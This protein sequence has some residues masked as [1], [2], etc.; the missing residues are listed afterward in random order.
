MNTLKIENVL[1]R[2]QILRKQKGYSLE[3]MANE[4]NL[5][6]SAYYKLEN[7]QSRLTLERLI[8]ISK[9]LNTSLLDILNKDYTKVYN[10]N[11]NEKITKKEFEYFNKGYKQLTEKMINV[12]EEEI[13]HLKS[14]IDFLREIIKKK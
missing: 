7:N 11:N 9:I 14:E 5:S 12:F 13:K 10:Q 2:I 4:L 6:H 8:E 1:S 3:N